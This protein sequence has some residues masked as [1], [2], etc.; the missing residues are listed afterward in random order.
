[1]RSKRILS[2]RQRCEREICNFH[3]GGGTGAA[4]CS[5]AIVHAVM[6]TRAASMLAMI[7]FFMFSP[8]C[9][10]FF[11][12]TRAAWDSKAEDAGGCF[13]L[14]GYAGHDVCGKARAFA[15]YVPGVGLDFKLV[16]AAL[17]DGR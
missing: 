8:L 13:K 10:C 3:G 14:E 16:A 15:P 2:I 1:M 4:F 11:L 9:I 12:A 5:A 6:E 17:F 7:A